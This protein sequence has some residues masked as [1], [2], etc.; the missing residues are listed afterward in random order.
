M[1]SSTVSSESAAR[2]STYEAFGVTSS[3]FTPSCS[4]TIFLTRSSMVLILRLPRQDLDQGKWRIVVEGSGKVLEFLLQRKAPPDDHVWC[5]F[6]IR[7]ERTPHFNR[8]NSNRL[9][10]KRVNS[11]EGATS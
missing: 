2:S 7:P 3:Y 6:V 11:L 1:T 9:L 5:I 10:T 4:T 8:P